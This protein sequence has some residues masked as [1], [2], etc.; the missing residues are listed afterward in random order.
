MFFFIGNKI[1][2]RLTDMIKELMY[3]KAVKG[4]RFIF[5]DEV[6]RDNRVVIFF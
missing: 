3:K 5:W 2:F 4:G 1:V 6:F